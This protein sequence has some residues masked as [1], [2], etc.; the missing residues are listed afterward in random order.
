ML[1]EP[2]SPVAVLELI[3]VLP[4]CP[5]PALPNAKDLAT[6]SALN[7]SFK[8]FLEWLL[9]F[10]STLANAEVLCPPQSLHDLSL[11]YRNVAIPSI[12]SFSVTISTLT[13]ISYKQWQKR[14]VIIIIWNP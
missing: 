9:F 12:L 8:G 5:S 6:F 7:P 11:P 4:S 14:T 10:D 3:C 2:L 13:D 1:G